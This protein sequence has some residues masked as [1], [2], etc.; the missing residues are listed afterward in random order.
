MLTNVSLKGYCVYWV[1][2]ALSAASHLSLVVVA[3]LKV[4]AVVIQILKCYTERV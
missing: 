3:Q 1:L 2:A 4:S